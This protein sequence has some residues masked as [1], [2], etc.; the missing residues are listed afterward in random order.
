MTKGMAAVLLVGGS[1]IVAAAVSRSV[2]D[3]LIVIGSAVVVA[4]VMIT[5]SED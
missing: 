4:A 3:A 5:F 1:I 2:L